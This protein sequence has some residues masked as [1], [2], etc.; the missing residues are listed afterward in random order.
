MLKEFTLTGGLFARYAKQ[1]CDTMLPFQEAVL[2]DRVEGVAPSHA[3]ENFVNAAAFLRGD[4]EKLG[5]F[6]G[7]VFQDSDVAKWIE[8]AAYSLRIK[9]D[10]ELERRLDDLCGLI[11]A[12][13]EDSGYLDTYYTLC[14]QDRRFTNLLEGHELYCAGHMMEAAVALYEVTGN[15]KLLSVM[16]KNADMLYRHFVTEGAEGYPGHPEVELALMRLWQATGEERYKELA[17]HFLNVRGVEPD[18]FVKE[19]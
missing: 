3:I 19:A 5:S 1:L 8:A 14:P 11:A 18:F 6:Y 9:P 16:R 7:M 17:E 4:Q 2:H 10:P 12:A 15:E 13:Q